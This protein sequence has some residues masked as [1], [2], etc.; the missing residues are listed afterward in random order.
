MPRQ[1]EPPQRDEGESMARYR[2]RMNAKRNAY[3]KMVESEINGRRRA[4]LK[5]RIYLIGE[6]LNKAEQEDAR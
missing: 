3:A 5:H 6:A 4:R 1:W 2:K